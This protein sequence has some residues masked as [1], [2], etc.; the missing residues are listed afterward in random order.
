MEN[1]QSLNK[2][3]IIVFLIYIVNDGL[4]NGMDEMMKS[5]EKQ[6]EV[7]PEPEKKSKMYFFLNQDNIKKKSRQ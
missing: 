4:F 7:K 5:P 1:L 2:K 6:P 3:K